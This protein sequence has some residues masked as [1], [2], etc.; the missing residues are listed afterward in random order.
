MDIVAWLPIDK[1]SGK[2]LLFGACATGQNWIEKLTE[3]QPE[4]FCRYYMREN[5][6]PP[7]AK[8]FFTSSIVPNESWGIYSGRAGVLF[9]RCRVSRF[10]PKLAI[11]TRHGTCGNGCAK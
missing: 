2:L 1:R 10:V 3:L 11:G 4:T 7:P 8:A 9:D 6:E 5:V